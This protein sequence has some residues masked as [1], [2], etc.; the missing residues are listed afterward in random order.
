MEL[1]FR[2][3]KLNHGFF[4][5]GFFIFNSPVGPGEEAAQGSVNLQPQNNLNRLFI[6]CGVINGLNLLSIVEMGCQSCKSTRI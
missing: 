2:T 5:L 6:L 4:P 3:L 1:R